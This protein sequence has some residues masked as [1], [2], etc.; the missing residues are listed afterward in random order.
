M[1][2]VLLNERPIVSNTALKLDSVFKMSKHLIHD[3]CFFVLLG[4]W[5]FENRDYRKWSVIYYSIC[6]RFILEWIELLEETSE[7]KL[8]TPD[9]SPSL[10]DRV[11]QETC[12][13][14]ARQESNLWPLEPESNALS[15]WAT[16]AYFFQSPERSFLSRLFREATGEYVFIWCV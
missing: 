15:S 11:G 5:D 16:G 7:T 12:E 14:C 4:G 3:I 1:V 8:S 10:N 9:G 2:S 6:C 13:L